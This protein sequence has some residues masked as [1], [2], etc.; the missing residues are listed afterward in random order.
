M[1]S[2]S[3]LDR[4]EAYSHTVLFGKW[5]VL[6]IYLTP[7]VAGPRPFWKSPHDKLRFYYKRETNS[8]NSSV[9]TVQDPEFVATVAQLR[10][11]MTSR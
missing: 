4:V 2:Q 5:D 3:L 11:K 1:I 10:E 8:N 6:T 7:H 9:W